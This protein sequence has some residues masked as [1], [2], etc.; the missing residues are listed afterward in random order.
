MNGYLVFS[1]PEEHLE[2][3]HGIVTLP[4]GYDPAG[5]ETLP[6][7]VFLHGSGESGD[8]SKEQIR[9]VFAHGIPKYFRKNPDYQGLRVITLSPQCPDGLTW[10]DLTLQLKD[11]IDAAAQRYGADKTRISLT[12][13]SR[14]GFGTWSMACAFPE[15]FWR[16]APICGGGV[17]WRADER[18]AGKPIRVF[19]SVDDD[20]VPFEC[21]VD[22]V[23]SASAAGADVTFTAYTKEG[24]G[25]WNRAYEE[26]DLIEWL[27]GAVD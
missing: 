7:I 24:H 25:C 10:N 12:G 22:M 1:R 26:G 8:G 13:L 6:M 17:S 16:L 15:A 23:R 3:L 14:G 21:S 27:A 5:E 20:S 18:F 11:F 4:T 9:R 2:G 19:H